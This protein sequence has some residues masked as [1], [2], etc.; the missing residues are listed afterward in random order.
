MFAIPRSNKWQCLPASFSM[1][2]QIPLHIF[3]REL[4]HDGDKRPY[5]DPDKRA[6]FHVQECIDVAYRFGYTCTPIERCPALTHTPGSLDV[7]PIYFGLNELS[8]DFRF[9][10]YLLESTH[11]VLEVLLGRE[12]HTKIGHAVACDGD[13]IHDPRGYLFPISDLVQR[14]YMPHTLWIIG[15]VS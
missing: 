5:P 14:N 4:G 2:C 7:Y 12:N 13:F 9:Y 11:S 8:N 10:N 6:G 1:A 15:G 3:M